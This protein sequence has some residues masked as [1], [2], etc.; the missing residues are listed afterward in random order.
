MKQEKLK[1]AIRAVVMLAAIMMVF[2]LFFPM[3]QIQL[4]APQ[5]PEGLALKIYPNKL[6]GDVDIIN[7]LNHYIGMKTLHTKDFMEFAILPYCIL[8]FAALILI[9]AFRNRKKLLYF[10]VIL[11]LVFCTVAMADFWKWE[12][13]YG[14]NLNAEAAI[15]V[16]GMTY[17]PPLLGYKQLLN[18]SAFSIPDT[19]GWIFIAAAALL[20]LC[21]IT[22]LISSKKQMKKS[23]STACIAMLLL[24]LFF[25]SC[26]PGPKPIEY[27][28]EACSY[29]TMTISDPHFGGEIITTKGKAYKFDDMHCLLSFLQ[30]GKIA[31]PDI[32]EMY[33][34]NFSGDHDLIKVDES[35]LL[36]K[37]DA[38]KSPMGG[39]IA[40]FNNSDSIAVLMAKY[41]K[42]IP[43]NWDELI[44]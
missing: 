39:N 14:H 29:C 2:V 34:V 28:Q 17:Q 8:F 37:C 25:T 7:G 33:A 13:N 6:A 15:Q 11:F 16:P 12:Y 30:E 42:G 24:P 31:K 18:F 5:Y 35:L 19:G 4:T 1:P 36:F 10:T 3:W 32:K 21:M 40:A 26:S 41:K 20:V 22:E 23:F 38:L 27:G 43:L 44:K 9:T